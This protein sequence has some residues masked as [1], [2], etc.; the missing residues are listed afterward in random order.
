MLPLVLTRLRSFAAF[1]FVSTLFAVLIAMGSVLNA[2]GPMPVAAT[3]TLVARVKN[4]SNQEISNASVRIEGP[5]GIRS[6]NTN[7]QGVAS[8]DKLAA[9]TYHVFAY[10]PEFGESLRTRV[11]FDAGRNGQ[12]EYP[13]LYLRACRLLVDGRETGIQP[14]TFPD[15]VSFKYLLM[16]DA[17][18]ATSVRIDGRL[19][20][21]GAWAKIAEV[22]AGSIKSGNTITFAPRLPGSFE[23]RVVLTHSNRTYVSATKTL[24][25]RFPHHTDIQNDPIVSNAMIREWAATKA[26]SK[27]NR[28]RRQERGFFIF[29]NT[30]TMRYEI[31]P[32]ETSAIVTGDTQ[33]EIQALRHPPADRVVRGDSPNG[34]GL[35]VVAVFHTHTPMSDRGPFRSRKVGPS[36]APFCNDEEVIRAQK[37]VGFVYDYKGS[38]DY[39]MGHFGVLTGHDLDIPSKIYAFGLERRP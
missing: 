10:T 11:V 21:T 27:P 6:R 30:S 26:F 1:E 24:S 14:V 31:G 16:G 15:P 5:G 2:Q 3:G 38:W 8:F 29:L 33:P 17:T 35:F 36:A 20:G 12:F 34:V 22:F 19:P 32:V 23:F 4:E 18:G 25:V 9:G 37:L 7:S 39:K 13:T 28:D